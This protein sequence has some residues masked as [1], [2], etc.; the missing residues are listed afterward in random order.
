MHGPWQAKCGFSSSRREI[1][2][3]DNPAVL[4]LPDRLAASWISMQAGEFVREEVEHVRE[5][6]HGARSRFV[7]NCKEA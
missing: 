3:S 6:K 7:H 5:G 1:C 2:M 4:A